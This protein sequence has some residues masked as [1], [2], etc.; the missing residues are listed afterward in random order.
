MFLYDSDQNDLVDEFQK[1]WNSNLKSA[2]IWGFVIS[3]LM[4]AA[5]VLCFIF[6]VSSTYVICIIASVLL[7][8]TGVMEIV[9]SAQ[10]P[11]FFRT[12]GGI[13]SGILN[14]L[15][16]VMVLTMRPEDM[17]MFYGMMFAVILLVSGVQEIMLG[18][19]MRFFDIG[20]NSTWMIVCGVISVIASVFFFFS[21]LTSVFAFSMLLAIYL[22]VWGASL[23]AGC[24]S[25]RE[26]KIKR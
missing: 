20:D 2:R 16:G 22:I 6:P 19:R 15:L 18:S 11:F 9:V 7:M 24:V 10:M 4:M 14:I 26:L 8:V 3:I 21:P 1:R 17:Q 13:V 5:G 23:F 25:A 12:G